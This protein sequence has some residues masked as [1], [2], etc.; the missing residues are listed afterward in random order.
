MRRPTYIA[1][2]WRDL[3]IKGGYNHNSGMAMPCDRL[4]RGTI[5]VPHL[6]EGDVILTRYPI[7]NSD[8]IHLYQNIHDPELKKT[9][10]VVWIHLP[11]YANSKC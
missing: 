9:R 3:A 6:P 1:N 5:C 2:Q 4:T 7:V 8:N 10:N 11:T